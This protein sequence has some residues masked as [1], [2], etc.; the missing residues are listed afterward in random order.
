MLLLNCEII[1]EEGDE[2]LD[3]EEL[4]DY[5]DTSSKMVPCLNLKGKIFVAD[6]QLINLEII[7]S[8][9][10]RLNLIK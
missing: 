7:Q 1:K 3:K 10:N 8:Y 9:I 6:D 5:T 2:D 4:G